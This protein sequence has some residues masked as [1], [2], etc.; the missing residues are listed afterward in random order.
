MRITHLLTFLLF[1]STLHAQHTSTVLATPAY[2]DTVIKWMTMEEAELAQKKNP[3][4]ILVSVYTSWCRW[5]KLE[6]SVSF[7]H[8]EIAH[9]INQNFYPVKFNA[10]SKVPL[11][12]NGVRY[13]F[14][15]E[16]NRYVHEFAQYALKGKLSYPGISFINE[17][18]YLIDAIYG[19]M[20]AY[21]MEAVLN[22]YGSSAYKTIKYHDYENDF[23][24]KVEEPE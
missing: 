10:E 6:D 8:K 2:K 12:F 22:Y 13:N 15:N 11:V 24:G 18:G 5:C 9:Y 17:T 4:K 1:V 21:Y 23:E 3:K 19:Y 16:E 20:D 7:R 14:I